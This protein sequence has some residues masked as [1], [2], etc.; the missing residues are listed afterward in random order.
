MKKGWTKEE[1]DIISEAVSKGITSWSHIASLLDGK[2]GKQCRERYYNHLEPNL[3][4]TAWSIDEDRLLFF[5]QKKYGNSWTRI[6]QHMP[7]RR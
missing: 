1:D 3:K 5:H 2:H 4:K 6:S 7:G